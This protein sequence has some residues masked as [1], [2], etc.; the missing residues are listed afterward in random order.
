MVADA[1]A[2]IE[3]ASMAQ[4]SS[5]IVAAD[6]I[7]IIPVSH[8]LSAMVRVPGS[9]SI[10]NRALLLAAMADGRSTIEAVL[11][12]DDTH[13][14]VTALRALGFEIDVDEAARRITVLGRDG[15]IPAKEATLDAGGAGTAM[16][17]LAG[18]L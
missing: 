17:F 7:E 10:T 6:E 1:E 12:S 8:P 16:R 5:S 3:R 14:M 9:K 15:E 2:R 4:I 13:R 18:F 11:I